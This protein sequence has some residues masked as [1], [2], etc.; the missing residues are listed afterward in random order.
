M[1]TRTDRWSMPYR[2][3]ALRVIGVFAIAGSISCKENRTEVGA[4]MWSTCTPMS[5]T[6]YPMAEVAWMG[7]DGQ[8]DISYIT[9]K[10]S[11]RIRISTV[12]AESG[13]GYVG[14]PLCICLRGKAKIGDQV[15]LFREATCYRDSSG[16]TFVVHSILAEVPVP[17]AVR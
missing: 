2:M 16:N 1:K 17:V 10:D 7:R 12:Q 3:H 15:S 6:P 4:R 13:S 14:T 8:I 9:T 5:M 11:T